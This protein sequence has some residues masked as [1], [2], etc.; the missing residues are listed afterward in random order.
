MDKLIPTINKL[1]DIFNTT[2][3]NINIDLPQIVVVG[4][5]S[6]GKSS[7]L[8]AIVGRDFL[9]RGNGI[10][11]RRPLVLQLINI[12]GN[13]EWGEFLHTSNK[14][15]NFKEIL[16]EIENETDRIT[17]T[18]KGI[19]ND[20][21]NLKIF[22]SHVLNL[23][24]VDLPGITRVAIGSQPLDI[25]KQ[26][27]NMIKFY[28][29]KENTIILA[30]T[31][32]N[33]DLSNS[34][35][36][37]LAKEVDPEGERTIGVL[38]KIDIMDRGTDALDMLLG[39]VIPLKHGFVGV[40]NRNQHDIKTNKSIREALIN[41]ETYFK[42]HEIYQSISEKL[43]TK[44]LAQKLNSILIRHI[45]K[46]LPELRTKINNMLIEK[47]KEIQTYGDPTLS[48]KNGQLGKLLQII[49]DF[50]NNYKN[51]IDGKISKLSINEIYGGARI[52]YIFNE[53]FSKCIDN[54]NPVEDLTLDEI[55]MAMNNATGPKGSLFVPQDAFE[56]LVKGQIEHLQDPCIQCIEK[57]YNELIMIINKIDLKEFNRYIGLKSKILE[58]VNN[59]FNNYKKPAKEMIINL[60]KMELAFININHPDFISHK[61]FSLV[62]EKIKNGQTEQIKTTNENPQLLLNN[63]LGNKQVEPIKQKELDID[64]SIR[65]TK[66]EYKMGNI[67]INFKLQDT[68]TE[69]ENFDTELI[70]HL[71]TS[72]FMIVRKNIK[73]FVPK[74][75]MLFLV[76]ESKENIQKELLSTLYREDIIDDILMEAPD[77]K[78]K[79]IKCRNTI[80]TLTSAIN[81]L[82]NLKE[83]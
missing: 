17:G 24:L 7:V 38:S 43:G 26:I 77:I 49:T 44:Y 40:I 58:V 16:K 39:N 32:A 64:Y 51:S 15:Y 29:K 10:V 55:R 46:C 78:E 63:I 65:Q 47:Q 20:P 4:S 73:D 18:N 66:Q 54:I 72:Y 35:A 31:P 30:I 81:I 79:R 36:I 70:K 67:P 76:N 71:I 56:I 80:D 5:Q 33:T 3:S 42:T 41:E 62:R 22:S 50:C 2:G 23:T 34:D 53:L 68:L 28:I 8:E 25:E 60:I 6:A 48:T 82:G 1:Q 19:S 69:K 27:R 14:K 9:P 11:T 45:E 12:K 75:I 59:I 61:A 74:T 57:V 52:K 83:I 13:E 21:I 37:Q